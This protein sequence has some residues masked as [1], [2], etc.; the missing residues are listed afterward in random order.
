MLL[1]VA[2]EYYLSKVF[3]C[4]LYYDV[5]EL[6]LNAIFCVL[7]IAAYRFLGLSNKLLLVLVGFKTAYVFPN[8]SLT[9]LLGYIYY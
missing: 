5:G 9:V 6:K 8:N 7:Y 4:V 2:E 3:Y 1:K